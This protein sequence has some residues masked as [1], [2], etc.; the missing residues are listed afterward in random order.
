VAKDKGDDAKFNK[1]VKAAEAKRGTDRARA[2]T[3]KQVR[4]HRDKKEGK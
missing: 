4:Q 2:V 3:D 1:R